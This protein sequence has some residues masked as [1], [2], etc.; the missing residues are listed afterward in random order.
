MS[1]RQ[2]GDAAVREGRWRTLSFLRIAGT[3]FRVA[4]VRRGVSPSV[5]QA[6]EE[7]DLRRAFTDGKTGRFKDAAYA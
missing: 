4:G 1:V 7:P 2:E 3:L 5:L 6:G